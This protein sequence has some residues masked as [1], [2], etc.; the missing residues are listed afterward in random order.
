MARGYSQVISGTFAATT[1]AVDLGRPYE[2]ALIYVPTLA[3]D[4]YVTVSLSYDG[5]TYWVLSM[6]DG[7]GSEY[8]VEIPEESCK[9]V[10]L[11]GCQYIKFTAP[12]TTQ[13]ATVRMQGIS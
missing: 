13:T 6:P 12:A 5:T 11:C 7:A 4:D 8:D 10:E 1:L 3:T 2:K 9:V